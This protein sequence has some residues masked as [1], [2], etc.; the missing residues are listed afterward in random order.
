[1]PTKEEMS[2]SPPPVRGAREPSVDVK[3][4]GFYSTCDFGY[5][6]ALPPSFVSGGTRVPK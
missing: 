4:M 6:F 5:E 2:P 1:M 3:V